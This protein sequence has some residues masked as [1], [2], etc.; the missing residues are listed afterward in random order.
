MNFKKLKN[1]GIFVI[2]FSLLLVIT[3]CNGNVNDNTNDSESGFGS[4]TKGIRLSEEAKEF[5]KANDDL[6][7]VNVTVKLYKTDESYVDP[8]DKREI[9]LTRAN[10]ED[11]YKFEDLKAGESYYIG[12]DIEHDGDDFYYFPQAGEGFSWIV[13]DGNITFAED[14]PIYPNLGENYM[15]YSETKEPGKITDLD[16]EFSFRD[17][18]VNNIDIISII[19]LGDIKKIDLSK[20]EA[21]NPDLYV[22][23]TQIEKIEYDEGLDRINVHLKEPVSFTSETTYSFT[24][25]NI[26]NPDDPN[27][28]ISITPRFQRSIEGQQL[29]PTV[30]AIPASFIIFP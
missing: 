22:N 2:I 16:I 1:I 5:I 14:Q 29:N 17:V 25:P 23:G 9:E 28:E 3:G 12:E 11:V 15:V 4:I 10:P 24:L 13:Q 8:V 7:K 19:F 27:N 18:D 26:E 20:A 21:N 30:T 6:S